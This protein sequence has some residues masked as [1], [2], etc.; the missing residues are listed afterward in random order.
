MTGR[1]SSVSVEG[2]RSVT[3]Y[4]RRRRPR[5][6]GAE[7]PA[8]RRRGRPAPSA[9]LRR[10]GAPLRRVRPRPEPSVVRHRRRHRR[11]PHRAG[12]EALRR[13]APTGG[14][15]MDTNSEEYYE[16][17]ESMLYTSVL[18]DVMDE[19]GHRNQ[20]M[21]HDIRPLADG[22]KL[23]GRAATMLAVRG[24]R[25]ARRAVQARARAARLDRAGR[26][27][28]LHDAGLPA[29][30]DVGRAAVDAHEG[31]GRPGRDHRRAHARRVGHR[32]HPVSRL[33]PRL[34][35]GRLEGAPRR[36]GDPRADRVR[37][38]PRRGR[39]PRRRR[40]RRLPGGPARR[41]AGGRATGRSPRWK[42][43]TWSGTCCEPGASI[44]QVFREHG[45][46]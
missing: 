27:G 36:D 34:L 26:G 35:A 42:A 17:I 46:L 41:R 38:G 29:G 15:V 22:A 40:R 20:V 4:C 9:R 1:Q 13:G 19:L 21:S 32:G 45:I 3:A 44:R 43:R 25:G 23:V 16:L 2:W 5:A 39:R 8:S 28:R 7:R 33:R 31:S 14:G 37:R 18:A 24:L 30:R 10:R 12:A 11:D 6:V